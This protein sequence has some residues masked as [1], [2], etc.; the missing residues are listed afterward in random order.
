MLFV[1]GWEEELY[2]SDGAPPFNFSFC[3]D[4]GTDF[5]VG[6][7]YHLAND[8]QMNDPHIMRVERGEFVR[9]RIINAAAMSSYVVQFNATEWGRE[10]P[11]PTLVAVDG[12]FTH[13]HH[14]DEFGG[15]WIGV[16][17]RGDVLLQAPQT[18]GCFPIFARNA[19]GPLVRR[20]EGRSE[21]RTTTSRSEATSIFIST[22]NTLAA[23]ALASLTAGRH[24]RRTAL[25][26]AIAASRRSH[27]RRK[28]R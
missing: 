23:L 1:A 9:L 24:L 5:D 11:R 10:L 2:G 16:A 28:E 3:M 7:R 21:E 18:D 22:T 19:M 8:R 17:Q 20:S 13:P 25:Q 15:F 6:F 14:V 12:Q 26:C 4:P 27:V